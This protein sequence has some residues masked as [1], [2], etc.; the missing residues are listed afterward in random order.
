MTAA[1]RSRIAWIVL[2]VVIAGL[3]AAHGWM[4]WLGVGV[5][6][7][8]TW[9]QSQG[10]AMGAAIAIGITAIEIIGTPLFALGRLVAPLALLYSA[11]YIVGIFMVHAQA[12][13]FVVGPGRNGMEF[14]VLL[15]VALLCVGAQHLPLRESKPA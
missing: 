7:F 6:P 8:A 10:L 11:I 14:S 3:I 1:E 2:R 9:L 13:W 15:I 12:G 5:E 4:R